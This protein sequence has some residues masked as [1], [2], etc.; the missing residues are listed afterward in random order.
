MAEG[1]PRL[2]SGIILMG[3]T[4]VL[5]DPSLLNRPHYLV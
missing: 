4:S 2:V 5:S 1:I 3:A